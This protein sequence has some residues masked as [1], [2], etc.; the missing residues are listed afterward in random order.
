MIRCQSEDRTSSL[1]SNYVYKLKDYDGSFFKHTN[2]MDESLRK[3]DN[4][5]NARNAID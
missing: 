4:Q 1:N 5:L 2:N 3:E